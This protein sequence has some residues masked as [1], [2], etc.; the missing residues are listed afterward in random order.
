MRTFESCLRLVALRVKLLL[1]QKLGWASAG[2]GG[3]LIVA[4]LLFAQASF[5][6]PHRIFWD[7]S[8]GASFATISL[9][10]LY[11]GTQ[12]VAEEQGRR[13]LHL[14]LASGVPRA[15]WW[16]GTG[17]G[18]WIALVVMLAGWLVVSCAVAT[19]GFEF[20]PLRMILEAQGAL[21]AE[22]LIVVFGGM[23]ISL[24]VRPW[25]AFLGT[26]ALFFFFHSVASVERIFQDPDSRRW[27]D[28]DGVRWM[29]KAAHWGPP[30]EWFDLRV[31]VGY[32][33]SAGFSTLGTLA[34]LALLWSSLLAGWGYWKFR[35]ID[36]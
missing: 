4:S 13:T 20:P 24:W 9:L 26:G 6:N 5:L 36:L 17:L 27:V 21:A 34:L 29:L 3:L 31:F 16:L 8:L 10:A 1:R 14:L 35:R 28:A 7:F 2:L 32:Q 30:L 15:A 33:E 22:L 25:L 19:W 12:V 23:A 11:L 18:L